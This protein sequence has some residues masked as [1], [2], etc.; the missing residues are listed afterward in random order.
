M[1]LM[2]LKGYDKN[3]QQYALVHIPEETVPVCSCGIS[4]SHYQSVNF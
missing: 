2:C 3:S 4:L 1:H